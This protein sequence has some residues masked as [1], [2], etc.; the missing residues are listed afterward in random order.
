MEPGYSKLIINDIVLPNQGA[1]RFAVQ[2]DMNMLALLASMERSDTK[3]RPSAG[4]ENIKIWPGMPESVIEAS[5]EDT[6]V[7]LEW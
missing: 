2:S 7:S 6:P 4:F 3:W 5:W 1:S